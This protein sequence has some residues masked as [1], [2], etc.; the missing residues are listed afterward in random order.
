MTDNPHR[1]SIRERMRAVAGSPSEDFRELL[2]LG[3]LDPAKDLRFQDWSGVSF[4]GAD[5]DG[6]D[7]TGAR[8]LSCDFRNASIAGAR[9]DAAEL[10]RVGFEP[11]RRASLHIAS[12]R[13]A[14]DWRAHAARWKKAPSSTG[15]GHLRIGSIFQD[16]PFAPEM[17]VV[18]VG[19]F[20]MGSPEDEEGRQDN[21]GPRRN[22]A[23]P[24]PFAVGRY[25]V[26]FEEW[27]AAAADGACG[28]YRPDDQ[29]WGRGRRPVINVNWRDAQAY[30]KW[31]R[32]KTGKG[33]RLLSEAEW[34]Y[35][36]RAGTTT[37]FWWGCS[38]SPR[39][40]N[41][42]TLSAFD[43]DLGGGGHRHRTAPVN[44]FEPNPWGLYQVHGNVREWVEDCWHENYAGA[45]DDGSPW[46]TGDWTTGDCARHVVRGGAWVVPSSSLRAAYRGK[47]GSDIRF[48]NVGF[49]VARTL[50]LLP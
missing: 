10:G 17:V 7:F 38:I 5:L 18:P 45:P 13:M 39:Q 49:R 46:M 48:S 30:V 50:S 15:D 3:D 8:L 29:K 42:N 19:R 23:M 25:A 40:A 26:T 12:L 27:D 36:A 2:R 22:V 21:E 34:E 14:A 1:R 47:V 33:Y 24:Q 16:A 43:G 31:L 32:K 41:Y 4:Q 11:G 37:P 9:F 6:C 44:E 20:L 35:A 28:G